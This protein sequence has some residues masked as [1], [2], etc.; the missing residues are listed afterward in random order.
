L[1]LLSLGVKNIILG[2]KLP[3]FISKNVLNVLIENFNIRSNSSIEEDMRIL[4]LV[5]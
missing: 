2:P 4:K 1:S 3:A 5:A